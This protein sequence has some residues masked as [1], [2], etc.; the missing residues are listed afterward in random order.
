[1]FN[2]NKQHIDAEG[3]IDGGRSFRVLFDLQEQS[4]SLLSLPYLVSFGC[5]WLNSQQTWWKAEVSL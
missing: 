4:Y 1:M 5:N 2:A 3:F